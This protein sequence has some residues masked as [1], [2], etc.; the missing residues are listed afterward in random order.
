MGFEYSVFRMSKPFDT[1]LRNAACGEPVPH[2]AH[3]YGPPV[4]S[5]GETFDIML[6]CD[7]QSTIHCG[8]ITIDPDAPETGDY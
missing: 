8:G 5:N 2:E 7:G 6:S 3:G 1:P 4:G